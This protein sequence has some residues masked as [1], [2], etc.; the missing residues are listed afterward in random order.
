MGNYF[1]CE[2]GKNS[3]ENAIFF[4]MNMEIVTNFEAVKLG[5]HIVDL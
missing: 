5:Y 3:K 1:S 2:E 4:S